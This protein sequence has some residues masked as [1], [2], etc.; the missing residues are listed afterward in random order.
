[1]N[2]MYPDENKHFEQDLEQVFTGQPMPETQDEAYQADLELADLMSR[3]RYVPAAAY[4]TRLHVH[5]IDQLFPTKEVK[6]MFFKIVRS[7]MVTVVAA[8]LLFVIVFAA[9]PDARA[10]TQQFVNRFV[11]ASSPWNAA[12]G[13][14]QPTAP[15]DQALEV[16]SQ[17]PAGIK[18]G[19]ASENGGSAPGIS[20]VVPQPGQKNALS[21]LISLD[22]AQKGIDF[23][24]LMPSTLPDGYT[25]QGVMPRPQ[26]PENV[27]GSDIQPPAD[28]PKMQLPQLAILVFKNADGEILTLS[29]RTNVKDIGIQLPVGEGSMQ[30]VSINGNPG[31]FVQGMWTQGGWSTEGNYF[32]TW[33]SNGYTLELNSRVL[34]LDQLLAVAESIQ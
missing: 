7:V 32:L 29:E 22:E 6:P 27:P 2:Q 12:P 19:S 10:A 25:F 21:D 18:P 17:N 13:G 1:M 8:L 4:K 11:E 9:S 26:V 15:G 23:T 16:G 34:G 33:T 30:D 14:K 5:L 28:M 20:G 24:I 3:A 31:Q